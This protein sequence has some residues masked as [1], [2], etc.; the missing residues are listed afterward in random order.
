MLQDVTATTGAFDS[1]CTAVTRASHVNAIDVGRKPL[2]DRPVG[3][4]EHIIY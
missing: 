2:S 3:L 1:Q 4:R